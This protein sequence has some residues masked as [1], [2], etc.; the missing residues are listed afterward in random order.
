M[1][2]QIQCEEEDFRIV[3]A[4]GQESEFAN[5]GDVAAMLVGAD[6]YYA[7]VQVDAAG[8][9]VASTAQVFRV[10]SVDPI[11]TECEDV[12]VEDEDDEDD[13]DE[14]EGEQEDEEEEEGVEID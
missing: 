10:A 9:L 6:I 14:G 12:E 8:E 11:E 3:S 13:E 2:F 7:S 4:D 1:A 5:Y